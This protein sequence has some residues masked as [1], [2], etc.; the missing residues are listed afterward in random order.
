MHLQTQK[1]VDVWTSWRLGFGGVASKKLILMLSIQ[2]QCFQLSGFID[3]FN[4]RKINGVSI[5]MY[6][7]RIR[8]VEMTPLAFST[9]GGLNG[10]TTVF[11]K[12]LSVILEEKMEF[13]VVM[14]WLCWCLSFLLLQSAI[15]CL[16]GA[17]W[18]SGQLLCA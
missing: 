9:S 3:F 4:L 6:E 10:A 17:L 1:M 13:S 12:S 8:K 18:L 16:R 2:F 7:Q 15:T 14:S 5:C 11:Y